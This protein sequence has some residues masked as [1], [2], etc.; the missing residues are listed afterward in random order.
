MLHY[1]VTEFQETREGRDGEKKKKIE[2]PGLV[3]LG[4]GFRQVQA[5]KQKITRRQ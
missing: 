4:F 1:G 5:K 2:W 3:E